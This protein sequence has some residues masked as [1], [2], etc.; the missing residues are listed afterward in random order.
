M[1]RNIAARH[2]AIR[3][4]ATP[5]PGSIPY[6]NSRPLNIPAA[7]D[8]Q[9]LLAFVCSVFPHVP[10][11]EWLARLEAGHLRDLRGNPVAL[12]Q[13]VRAGER[14]VQIFPATIE[15]EVNADIRVLHEDEAV[16][17]VH[18]PAPLPMHPSGRFNRNTLQFL[19][20]QA[21]APEKPR[22]L[23][24]L[25]ANTSGLVVLARSRRFAN[26]LQ[27]QFLRGEVEKIYLARVSGAPETDRFACDA[28]I[29]NT[30]GELGSRAIDESAESQSA[31]TE[32]RVRD[33]FADGTTLLEA[34]PIT[35]RTNQIRVHLWHLGIPICGDPTYLADG[36]VGDTQTLEVSAPPLWLHSW[37]LAFRHPLSGERLT[38]QTELPSWAAAEVGGNSSA[39]QPPSPLAAGGAIR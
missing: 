9:S 13:V 23:H 25:D 11:E 38:F 39:A 24:R 17:V 36:R 31:R 27:P 15:P 37:R 5:L 16:V 12:E 26:L 2:E 6:E 34:R 4:A 32:F 1:A 19:L 10:R 8:G 33:R 20:A 21:Y 22:H 29:S 18:K 3:R 28:R 14:Y 35:G 30:A 7:A